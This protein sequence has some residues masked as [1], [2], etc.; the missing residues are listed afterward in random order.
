MSEV[1]DRRPSWVSMARFTG[2]LCREDQ[3]GCGNWRASLVQ[4]IKENHCHQKELAAS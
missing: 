1:T 3:R 4:E 2:L